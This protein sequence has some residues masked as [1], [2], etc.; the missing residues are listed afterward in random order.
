MPVPGLHAAFTVF[1]FIVSSVKTVRSSR[2][3]LVALTNAVGQLLTTL[4][5][6]F[7]SSRLVEASWVQPLQDLMSLLK[8]IHR[9]VQIEQDRSFRKVLLH[10][11]SRVAN[12]TIE[13]FYRRIGHQRVQISALLNIQHMLR[14]NEALNERFSLLEKNHSQLRREL[15]INQNNMLAMMVS[16]EQRMDENRGGNIAEQRFY[17][18]TMYPCTFYVIAG[19][20][21]QE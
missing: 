16:I 6:E 4:Q 12:P 8:D 13:V 14:N 3:Q 20:E 9:F 5:R 18:H 17:S 15:D 11:D 7:E 10:A 2:K 21:A 1:K 19:S